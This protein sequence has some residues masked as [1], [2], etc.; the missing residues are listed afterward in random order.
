MKQ[1]SI[2]KTSMKKYG[3]TLLLLVGACTN[4]NQSQKT[5]SPTETPQPQ[6]VRQIS[7]PPIPSQKRLPIA[8]HSSLSNGIQIHHVRFDDRDYNLRVADQPQGLGSRWTT[9]QQA[10]STYNGIAAINGGFFTPEGKPLGLLIETGTKRGHLNKSSLGAGIY[11]SGATHSGIIR[12]EIY[13]KSHTGWKAYNLLQTGPMLVENKRP[14]TGLSNSNRR[15]RSFMAWDGQHHWLIGYA[16]PC[17]LNELAQAIA[18]KTLAGFP[19]NT[20]VNL[21]G[22]RSSDLWAGNA[23]PEGN[24]SHRSIFNKPVRNYLVLVAK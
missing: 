15:P 21:D 2:V 14:V 4:Y 18:G 9:A 19:M 8:Y 16:E 11:V 17:T 12:R 22:G 7:I 3:W 6:V 10:A 5:H 24:K 23:I 1:H 13:Q 20:A